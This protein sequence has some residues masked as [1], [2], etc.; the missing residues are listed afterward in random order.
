MR[1]PEAPIGWPKET[2]P[3]LTLTI[4]SPMPRIL[5][6]LIATAANA[7]FISTRSRSSALQP[8]FS[9]TSLPAFPGTEC[10]FGGSSATLACATMVPRGSMFRRSAKLSLAGAVAAEADHVD[11]LES[12]EETIVDHGVYHRR[13]THA[14]SPPGLL[15]EVW[16][17]GHAL[18]AAGEDHLVVAAADHVLRKRGAPDA[19]GADLVQCLGGQAEGYPCVVVRLPGG[20]LADPRLHHDAEDG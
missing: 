15:R 18:H 13:V 2:A 3:P 9:N 4:C 19:R 7:S 6:E 11:V 8:G 20:D 5:L 12:V 17:V 10:K 14:C 1:A 16:G